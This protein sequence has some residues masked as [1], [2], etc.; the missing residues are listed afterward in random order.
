[1]HDPQLPA[2]TAAAGSPSTDPGDTT[3]PF[4]RLHRANITPGPAM[5]ML[6]A[7]IGRE[8]VQLLSRMETTPLLLKP[9][10]LK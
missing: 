4:S 2:V 5:V 9:R 7:N 3:V 8:P 1:L 10:G 6:R